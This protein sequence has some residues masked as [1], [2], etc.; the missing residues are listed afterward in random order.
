MSLLTSSVSAVC[1]IAWCIPSDEWLTVPTYTDSATTIIGDP[2]CLLS[3][4]PWRSDVPDP[5]LQVPGYCQSRY[6]TTFPTVDMLQASNGFSSWLLLS[7]RIS[8]PVQHLLLK[9]AVYD[10][11]DKY[12]ASQWCAVIRC[13][14]SHNVRPVIHYNYR[15]I[16]HECVY[17]PQRITWGIKGYVTSVNI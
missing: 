13:A 1:V 15:L 12:R 3:C 9:H 4:R 2:R 14:P 7:E 11:S 10:A 5:I 6:T 17:I 16:R 8:L